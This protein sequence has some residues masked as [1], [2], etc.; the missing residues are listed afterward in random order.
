MGRPTLFTPFIVRRILRCARRGMPL[1]AACAV[2]GVS[3]STLCSWRAKDKFFNDAL[4]TAIAKGI[5]ASLKV[6][7]ESLRSR[8]PAI[9]LRAACWFLE[10]TQPDSFGRQR[11]DVAGVGSFEHTFAVPPALLERLAQA[12]AEHEAGQTV[13][14]PSLPPGDAIPIPE[15][16][17]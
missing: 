6:V 2:V 17:P 14:L 3:Y 5:D 12:R 7:E 10:K 4:A 9:R 8:E 11:I 1:S 15:K 16:T 13:S